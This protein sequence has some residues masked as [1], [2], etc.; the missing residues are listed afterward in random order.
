MHILARKHKI[1][2]FLPVKGLSLSPHAHTRNYMSRIE[3]FHHGEYRVKGLMIGYLKLNA[4]IFPARRVT[5]FQQF[6]RPI[7]LHT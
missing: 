1:H 2:K 7:S 5:G 6:I 3:E 4:I